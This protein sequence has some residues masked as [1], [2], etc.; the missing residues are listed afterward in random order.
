MYIILY[1]V[2]V[3]YNSIT[4]VD[5]VLYLNAIY[6]ARFHDTTIQHDTRVHTLYIILYSGK[7]WLKWPARL[8]G[9]AATLFNCQIEIL[10]ASL[11]C[12]AAADPK[13]VP[14]VCVCAPPPPVHTIMRIIR[15]TGFFWTTGQSFP[16]SSQ[17]PNV[18]ILTHIFAAP[19]GTQF[20]ARTR[21]AP[22]AGTFYEM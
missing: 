13:S 19:G 16:S 9:A 6:F 10:S 14:E 2:K 8:C 7:T 1:C 20:V 4:A 21:P 12:A 18:Y 3:Y 5:L 15:Q 22:L 17:P 11:L